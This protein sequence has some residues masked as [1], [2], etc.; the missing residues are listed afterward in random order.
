MALTLAADHHIA[1]V[2][3]I[4]PSDVLL[5]GNTGIE[6][7]GRG[8]RLVGERREHLLKRPGLLGIAR[9]DLA[10]LGKTTG[11]KHQGQGHQRTIGALFLGMPVLCVII[12]C[13]VVFPLAQSNVRVPRSAIQTGCVVRGSGV[14]LS[15]ERVLSVALKLFPYSFSFNRLDEG[16]RGKACWVKRCLKLSIVRCLAF[17]L[18]ESTG[19]DSI[20]IVQ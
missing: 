14:G 15:R 1:V 5:G 6:H 18:G 11:I 17:R 20:W 9:K 4:E 7:H 8:A 10:A 19:K 16:F 3:C 12:R 13:R 2:I